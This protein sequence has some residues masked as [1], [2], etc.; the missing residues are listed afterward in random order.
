MAQ[1]VA[2]SDYWWGWANLLFRWLHVI[3]A[4]AWIGASF[5]FIALDNHLEAPRD[6]DDLNRGIGGEAWEVHGGADDLVA[7]LVLS[8]P[9][10]VDRLIVGGRD[11]VRG[12]ALVNADEEEIAR[13]HRKHAARLWQQ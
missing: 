4:M 3:A 1:L 9:H 6:P 13:E 12:R 10:R 8:G 7:N 11:V 2:L 5:Y